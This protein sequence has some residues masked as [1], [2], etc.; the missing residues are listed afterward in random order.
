VVTVALPFR[1]QQLGLP[2]VQYGIVVAAW[3]LGALLTETLWG[4]LAFRLGVAS[5]ILALGLGAIAVVLALGFART[6]VAFAALEGLFGALS[7]SLTPLIRWTAFTAGGPGSGGRGAG[8]Y[9]AILGV[10][11]T[12]GTVGG[13]LAFIWWEFE[14]VAV[15]SATL[16]AVSLLLAGLVPWDLANL[17]LKIRKE[18]PSWRSF[19][20]RPFVLALG[21]VF[22]GYIAYTL[23]QEFFQYYSIDLYGGTVAEAGFVL[24][25]ARIA[26]LLGSLA[27]GG[28][29]DRRGSLRVAVPG[30]ALL[31]IGALGSWA[32]RSYLELTLATLLFS[33][34][35]GWLLPCL[36]SFAMRSIPRRLEGTAM[37]LLGSVEDFGQLVGPVAYGVSWST[38]GPTSIF[39]LTAVLAAS[40]GN[41]ATLSL[42]SFATSQPPDP[43][44]PEVD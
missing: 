7:I 35:Q 36:T 29:A 22:V 41:V 5:R 21:L 33:A 39:P 27:I 34:A 1:F 23:P 8:R 44:G 10:G 3:A 38:F 20:Q 4:A 12:V 15:L 2:I 25:G 42:S 13:P 32:S 31:A 18:R 24:G 9:S 37:G 40:G 43:T 14:G 6:F 16:F 26:A 11:F 30:F 19:G 28:L 17:P